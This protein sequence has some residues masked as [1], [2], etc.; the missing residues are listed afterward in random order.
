VDGCDREQQGSHASR[1]DALFERV[2]VDGFTKVADIAYVSGFSRGGGKTKV[3][4]FVEVAEH[5]A[6]GGIFSRTAAM[7]LV[8][9][10][11]Y[12]EYVPIADR[13][14]NEH[15]ETLHKE[16]LIDGS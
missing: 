13:L 14:Y 6:P 7:T 8:N 9:D 11:K 3:S 16:G 10:D 4:G 12:E 2:G 1:F 15:L 5:F